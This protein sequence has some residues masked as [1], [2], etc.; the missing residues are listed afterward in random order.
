MKKIIADIAKS[1]QPSGMPF[2]QKVEAPTSM[3]ISGS[4]EGPATT[5]PNVTRSIGTIEA[6]KIS[7]PPDNP[8]REKPSVWSEMPSWVTAK[9]L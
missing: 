3:I 8:D 2:G 5:E 9:H 1:F 4:C 7:A 6:A